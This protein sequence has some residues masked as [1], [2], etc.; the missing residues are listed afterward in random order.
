MLCIASASR[1]VKGAERAPV[2]NNN[3]NNNGSG[4]GGGLPPTSVSVFGPPGIANFLNEMLTLSDTYLAMPVLVHEFGY[5]SNNNKGK[6]GLAS[7]VAPSQR[8]KGAVPVPRLLSRRAKLS[9]ATLLPDELNPFGFYDLERASKAF[10]SRPGGGQQGGSEGGFDQ[11]KRRTVDPDEADR[12]CVLF[13][14]VVEVFS[15]FF[16]FRFRISKSFFF[17]FS[18]SFPSPLTQTKTPIFSPLSPSPHS[19]FGFGFDARSGIRG[20]DC[21]PGP[22][23][24]ARADANGLLRDPSTATWTLRFDREFVVRC[25][26]LIA[27]PSDAAENGSGSQKGETEEEEYNRL[28]RQKSTGSNK[29]TSSSSSSSPPSAP[30]L[31]AAQSVF[32]SAPGPD[33]LAYVIRESAR[34]GRID[35]D[36]AVSLGVTRGPMMAEL[37]A[38]RSVTVT[39]GGGGGGEEGGEPTTTRVVRPEEVV[40]PERPGRVVA[41]LGDPLPPRSDAETMLAPSSPFRAAVDLRGEEKDG[42]LEREKERE[43]RERAPGLPPRSGP[44]RRRS[45]RSRRWSRWRARPTFSS[46]GRAPRPPPRQSRTAP[47]RRRWC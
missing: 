30:V 19:G 21:L 34:A 27:P 8:G 12:L 43:R 39:V 7:M 32:A 23:D 14:C 2:Q 31:S 6:N 18:S 5:G 16:F 4:S 45:R 47:A 13:L 9:V 35:A 33:A 44:S 25:A 22:G 28:Q 11:E 10:S 3:N 42:E 1:V 38:G 37:K 15:S 20:P 36:L 24:P 26:P 29:K 40:S 46:P 17:F 41:I